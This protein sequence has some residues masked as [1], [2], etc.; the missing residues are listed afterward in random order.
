MITQAGLLNTTALVVPGLYVQIVPPQ[1]LLINGV[2][3]DIIG[4]VGTATWGP[5]NTP[6][7]VGSM[8]EYAA[9]FGPVMARKYDLGTDVMVAVQQGAS[10]FR[11]VRA[12]D[13]SDT[14]A[15]VTTAGGVFTARY[16]GSLGNALTMTYATG[17]AASTWKVTIGLPTM[18]PE[19]YD[20]IAGTGAAFWTNLASA[21][22]SGNSALRGPSALISATTNAVTTMPTAGTILFSGSGTLGTDGVVTLSDAVM[23][24]SDAATPRTGLYALRGQGCAIGLLAGVNA[25]ANGSEMSAFALSETLY[26]I[27]SGPSND[28]VTNAINVKSAAGIDSYGLK[29]LFG[30]FVYWQDTVNNV[31]RLISPTAFE[32]GRLANLSPNQS[33]LNKPIYEI[34]GSQRSGLASS[35]ASNA[36][37]T[38]D[39][40]ALFAAGIDVIGNPSP[41]GAY[42][43]A[44]LGH[45]TSSNAVINGDNYTRM[46]NY[47][48]STLNSAMGVFVGMVVTPDLFGE[49][50]GALKGF[51][52]NLVGQKL[53]SK[54]PGA[55][56]NGSIKL[57][58]PYSVVCDYTN[59]PLSRT[60]LGYVQAD[61][62]IQY[63]SINEKFIVNI[64]GGV[65]V[66]I[67]SQ[68]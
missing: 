17:S 27:G 48:A 55:N 20:N 51:L 5:V 37:A 68:T 12:T 9:A 23:I 41:G 18:T 25:F 45:N 53:L 1:N 49:I 7:I 43:S 67:A 16:T 33:S 13:G 22:N 4:A 44:L 29:L 31:Q 50:R 63:Q 35:G 34:L 26:M 66:Q 42:W 36:W 65:S 14:A 57:V 62:Q 30:D 8:Q 59:N 40:E 38:A 58:L 10:N 32:A 46:T 15:S 28:T 24:G 61:V 52:S 64:E 39:L 3:S 19:V 2:P 11:C 54:T 60:A 47:I 21:I 6:V 56:S